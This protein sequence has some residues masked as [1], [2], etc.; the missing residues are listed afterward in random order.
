[1]STRRARAS[2]SGLA[3]AFVPLH[4]AELHFFLDVDPR[5]IGRPLFG[6][7]VA[8]ASPFGRN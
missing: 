6:G 1:M 3:V 8:P 4:Q 7:P 5:G 2:L